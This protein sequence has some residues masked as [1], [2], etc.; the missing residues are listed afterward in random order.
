MRG[1]A[2]GKP[3]A[4]RLRESGGFAGTVQAAPP[5]LPTPAS[6]PASSPWVFLCLLLCLPLPSTPRQLPP[7]EG[8]EAKGGAAASADAFENFSSWEAG[9]ASPA[10]SPSFL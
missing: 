2:Q 9:A 8:S 7:G 4:D 5:F 3:G 1:W 6:S 10:L